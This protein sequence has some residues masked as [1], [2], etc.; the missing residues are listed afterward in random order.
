[1]VELVDGS[2]EAV[3]G[4]VFC[5]KSPELQVVELVSGSPLSLQVE[6]PAKKPKARLGGGTSG[7]IRIPDLFKVRSSLSDKCL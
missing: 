2:F 3:F 7:I 5:L 6:P 1:M 4:V